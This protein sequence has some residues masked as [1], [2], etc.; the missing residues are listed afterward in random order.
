MSFF[1]EIDENA[2]PANALDG[3]TIESGFRLGNAQAMMWLS[4]L[5]YETADMTKVTNVLQKLNL[6]LKK[7]AR[8]DPI[9]GLPPLSCCLVAAAGR[10]A[11]FFSFAGSD[12]LKFEDWITDFTAIRSSDDLHSGFKGAVDSVWNDK[13]RP[14]IEQ[15]PKTEE[16]LF[17]TGHSLGGALAI[18]AAER[19]MRELGGK[20][21]AVYT[22]G[23]PRMGGP[24][25]FARYTQLANS[26]FRLVH[27]NDLVPTVPSTIRGNFLHVGQ[28]V[29]CASGDHFSD[30]TP[31]QPTTGNAPD[32][33]ISALQS[34]I[35]TIFFFAAAHPFSQVG[36]RLLDQLAIALPPMVRDHIPA[37]YFRALS[38]PLK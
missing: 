11:T 15:R 37:N 13:I 26:T 1:V 3:L 30:N 34:A 32:I 4:Q 33:G 2:Y 20:A 9:T 14:V 23:S 5:A 8:N 16:K 6:S 28:F 22:F 31:R 19:A 12:P 10:E 27:N 21:T 7:F 17:F 38:I 36:P 24:E 25:F 35:A 18:V 29:H